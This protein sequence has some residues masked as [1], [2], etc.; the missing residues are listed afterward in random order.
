MQP[1]VLA[2]TVVLLG[3]SLC[4]GPLAA[5]ELAS[6]NC[7]EFDLGNLGETWKHV[8]ATEG[9]ISK[10]KGPSR[11]VYPGYDGAAVAFKFTKQAY[12]SRQDGGANSFF[13]LDNDDE[14]TFEAWVQL[15]SLSQHAYLIGKGRTKSS[16]PLSRNQNWAFRIRKVDGRACV[17]F[18]FRSRPATDAADSE[19]SDSGNSNDAGDWHRW[20]SKVGFSVD[21]AWHRVSFSY[22]FGDPTSAVATVDGQISSGNW[23]MGGP[24]TR[25]PVVDDDEIWIGSSMQGSRS[26]SLDG[27]LVGLK[28]HRR[29]LDAKKLASG[30]VRIE[31]PLIKPDFNLEDRVLVE[32]FGPHGAYDRFPLETSPRMRF[33]APAMA[34][35]EIPN[36][37]DDYGVIDDWASPG[38]GT[39]LVRAWKRIELEPGEYRF[40][41]RSRGLSR[42]VIDGVEIAS[43]P[44]Q[45]GRGDAHHPVEPIPDVPIR[46][47]RP[48]YMNDHE[49]VVAFESKGGEHEVRFDFNVGSEKYVM[50]VGETCVAIARPGEMFTLLGGDEAFSLD[51]IGWA[52]FYKQEQVEL[53]RLN[54]QNRVQSGD[55]Q[56]AYWDSRHR[57]AMDLL[58]IQHSNDN[59]IAGSGSG[60]DSALNQLVERGSR[61][62]DELIHSAIERHNQRLSQDRMGPQRKSDTVGKTIKA[63]GA[64][65][66][67]RSHYLKHVAPV[68]SKHC[69]RCHGGQPGEAGRREGGLAIFDSE[70]LRAGGDS[71]T[72]AI[73]PGDRDASHLW[74]L[75]TADKDDYRMPPEGDGL[76]ADELTAIAE[77]IDEGAVI[78]EPELQPIEVAGA[79]DDL[80][81]LR[82]LAI[83]TVGVP[84]TLAEI[85][86][87][88]DDKSRHRR[89]NA[90]QR[91]VSDDRWADNW[92]GY[93]QDVLAENPNLLKPK[94]NN[95]GPF[96]YWIHDALV[97]N[98]PLDR[99][100]TELMMMR[101]SKWYGGAAGFEE[102]SLNDVPM[103]AKANVVASAFLG[104]ELKC[105]RCHDAPYHPWK[106]SDLFELA[107]MMERSAIELPETSAVPAAFF[108]KQ[109]RQS[110]IKAT[111][112]PGTQVEAN[113]PERLLSTE[114]AT[115]RSKSSDWLDDMSDFGL[116]RDR[117]DTRETAAFQITSSRRFAEVMANRI[118]TRLMGTG[119]V[120][121]ANDWYAG[122]T[123]NSEL[124]GKLGELLIEC[125]FDQR[126]F[127]EILLNTEIYARSVSS[128]EAAQKLFAGRRPRRLTAE[129]IVDSA[130]A[131]TGNE[132]HT[133][134]LTLDL[135]G[136]H[137]AD[138]FFN[139]GFP[140]R[141]WEFTTLANERDR[142]SLALPRSQAVTDVLQAFGWRDSRPE[143]LSLRDDAPNLV[144]PGA[145]ANGAV[146]TWVTRLSS[147]SGV[148]QL[149]ID[150]QSVDSFVRDVYLMMLTRRPTERELQTFTGLLRPGFA[151][152][153]IAVDPDQQEQLPPARIAKF[154]YVSWSNHLLPEANQIKIL[155]QELAKQGEPPT[156]R[157]DP[158]W[159]ERAEDLVWALLNSPEMIVLR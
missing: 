59:P 90:V 143:P 2:G 88:L 23:D 83:D 99:F 84:P 76:D 1:R 75:V 100:A 70:N 153:L 80:T 159:R 9:S 106:Q 119:V 33:D 148:T 136:T 10:S 121:K 65:E 139:F 108:A 140:K 113:W 8:E 114:E 157:L 21:D 117:G 144:Q 35:T 20:T 146:G 45:H 50:R 130:F 105:A 13:D 123:T 98:K 77:W 152:R 131:A 22:R 122:E 89:A 25:P 110:L 125:R 18:L 44:K 11:I 142:P 147:K 67:S 78:V 15:N 7:R 141:A 60:S 107:A 48:H 3:L 61:H 151:E 40:L 56:K 66:A 32:M 62:I 124:L 96:R 94:L 87:Y 16:G 72:P 73:V 132:I 26:N 37:Y 129:Q 38:R 4:L 53:G 19:E 127:A 126:R 118:W 29:L 31:P 57:Y 86:E 91:F 82:R 93:W 68:L 64:S 74:Q 109:T 63:K 104:V 137:K 52:Q 30:F 71:E 46:G 58:R 54:R 81:F 17:N 138:W 42:L 115:S 101:G 39:L 69:G 51:E 43:T 49:K 24:T 6:T 92:T 135:E 116:L 112:K 111:L 47:M 145:L 28:M 102:A 12:L 55:R 155:Q 27:R 34:F 79:V 97:D 5:D 150:A 120:S 158:D 149:A 41:V 134:M 154:P 14:V 128:D 36:N 103:A 85:Q 156:P 133:E 95:T